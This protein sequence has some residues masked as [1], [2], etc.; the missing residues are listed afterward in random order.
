[1]KYKLTGSSTLLTVKVAA[2]G[3]Y[4]TYYI[5]IYIV[6]SNDIMVCYIV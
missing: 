5:G 6:H 1:M 4:V 3:K 2:K